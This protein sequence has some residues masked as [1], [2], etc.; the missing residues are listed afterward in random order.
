MRVIKCCWHELLG[1]WKNPKIIAGFL[2]MFLFVFNALKTTRTFV[3]MVG[4]GVTPW[5]FPFLLTNPTYL[6]LIELVLLFLLCDIPSSDQSQTFILLRVGKLHWIIGQLLYLTV[7]N[8]ILCFSVYVFSV[9]CMVPYVDFSLSWGKAIGTLAQTTAASQ[10]GT[11]SFS[12][13]IM[14]NYLPLQATTVSFL[15]FWLSEMLLGEL[16][17]LLNL[18]VSRGIAITVSSVLVLLPYLIYFNDAYFLLKFSPMSWCNLLYIG[19]VRSVYPSLT[20]ALTV[21]LA[22]IVILA[23]AILCCMHKR[24]LALQEEVR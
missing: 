12:Y 24:T 18:F 6:M 19:Q 22:G 11:L 3:E 8:L 5:V 17:A 20:Y 2:I 10:Y 23:I 9:I 13:E 15:L 4:V 21:L 1:W 14:K 16:L 7:A